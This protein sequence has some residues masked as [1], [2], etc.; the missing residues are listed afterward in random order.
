APRMSPSC[1]RRAEWRTPITS[2]PS[3]IVSCGFWSTA[4]SM[5]REY[6]SFSSPLIAKTAISYPSTSAP[7]PS[8]RVGTG[9]DAHRAMSRPPRLERPHQVRGLARDVQ[10]R[11]DAV[12]GQ[13]LLL[14]E[15]VADRGEHRHL[16]VGPLDPRDALGGERQIL[17]VV[18]LRRCHLVLSSGGE[19]AF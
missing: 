4:A 13:R 14:H 1:S 10:A 15:A 9:V 12:A 7:A 17:D 2:A 19:Q 8:S 18:S 16:P 11:G 5:C 6:V 3:S